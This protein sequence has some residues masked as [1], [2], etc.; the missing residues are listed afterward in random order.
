MMQK[1][2]IDIRPLELL[3][4]SSTKADVPTSSRYCSKPHVGG[5]TVGFDETFT[6]DEADPVNKMLLRLP[7]VFDWVEFKGETVFVGVNIDATKKA[8][9]PMV[10][11]FYCA[12]QALNDN[13]L[14]TTQWDR[15]KFKPSHLGQQF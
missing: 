5:C 3:P 11:V 15:N 13:V 2:S 12:T 8:G 1:S 6:L 7:I 9:K 10:D 14:F 4:N